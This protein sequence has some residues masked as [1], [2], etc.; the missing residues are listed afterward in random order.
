MGP[1]LPLGKRFKKIRSLLQHRYT[2]G[3]S[4]IALFGDFLKRAQYAADQVYFYESNSP[5]NRLIR[6]RAGQS[7]HVQ[8]ITETLKLF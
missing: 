2:V 6:P 3:W 8:K 1:P 7:F 4:D 5:K